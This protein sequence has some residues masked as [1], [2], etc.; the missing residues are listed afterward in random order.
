MR[1]LTPCSLIVKKTGMEIK[2]HLSYNF[3]ICSIYIFVLQNFCCCQFPRE[4]A[5][6]ATRHGGKCCPVPPGM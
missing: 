4:C 6:N 5:E 2:F 1:A 3:W